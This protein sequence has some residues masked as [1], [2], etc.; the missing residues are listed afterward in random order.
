MATASQSIERYLV[1]LGQMNYS[2]R[3]VEA[4]RYYLRAFCE[5]LADLGLETVD[6]VS[7]GVLDAYRRHVSQRRRW[8]DQ[9]L[10]FRSQRNR[11]VPVK[12]F[13]RWLRQSRL[14]A[15]NP[16]SEMPMPRMEKRLPRS[17][18][19]VDSV[20]R[21]LALAS[22]ETPSTLRDRAMLETFYSSGI[23]RL[24]LANLKIGDADL[25]RGMLAIRKGKGSKDRFVPIGK[26]AGDWISRYLA[27]SRPELAA[28]A[29]ESGALQERTLFL[30]DRGQPWSLSRLSERVGKYVKASSLGS[31]GGCHLFRHACA[32][33]MLENG[34]D[35]R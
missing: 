3:T 4:R 18:P 35:I 10:S 2:P 14:I 13:F 23:R 28:K 17:V 12:S 7:E 11:L 8:D 29:G 15:V 16:A 24:E 32:T 33:H 9:P 21:C 27:E 30:N 22:G 26:R 31:Q 19:A 34:A 25:S 20:E 6:E 5:W 1:W